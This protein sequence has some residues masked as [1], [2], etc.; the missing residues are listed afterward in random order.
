MALIRSAITKCLPPSSAGSTSTLPRQ[1]QRQ[2]QQSNAGKCDGSVL[3]VIV[4]GQCYGQIVRLQHVVLPVK[5][6]GRTACQQHLHECVS[7]HCSA[8]DADLF[9]I[10]FSARF[11]HKISDLATSLYH[12]DFLTISSFRIIFIFNEI[13]KETSWLNIFVI[14][15]GFD[16]DDCRVWRMRASTTH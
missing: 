16:W 15:Y 13:F 5:V 3:R 12:V 6:G 7:H 4:T 2:R 10:F 1:R 14:V 11:L 8:V 9:A